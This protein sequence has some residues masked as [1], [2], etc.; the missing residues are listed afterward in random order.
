M[1]AKSSDSSNSIFNI[2]GAVSNNF[3]IAGARHSL[4][5]IGKT[6][7]EVSANTKKLVAAVNII[8]EINVINFIDVTH[9]HV[10]SEDKLSKILRCSDFKKID[11]SKELLLGNVAIFGDIKVLENGFQMDA[12]SSNSFAVLVEDTFEIKL[13][14]TLEVLATSKKGII[15]CNGWH[16]YVRGFLNSSGGKSLVN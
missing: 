3:C 15:L 9:I 11:N 8:T 1:G 13:T 4:G 6:M 2:V 7:V 16:T 10:L 14:L 5:E 12:A